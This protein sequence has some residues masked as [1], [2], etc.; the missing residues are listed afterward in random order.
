M[1]MVWRGIKIRPM[2][3]LTGV[4]AQVDH[5]FAKMLVMS[6]GH[7]IFYP[8]PTWSRLIILALGFLEE[9]IMSC[10]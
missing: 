4:V 8:L 10:I 3:L 1:D 7:L 2:L 6:L 9:I 5:K